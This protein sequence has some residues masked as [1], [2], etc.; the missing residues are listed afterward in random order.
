MAPLTDYCRKNFR[1]GIRGRAGNALANWPE[2][3]WET[4]PVSAT[5]DEADGVFILELS[6]S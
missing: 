5:F 4:E 6:C 2:G 3:A 1:L